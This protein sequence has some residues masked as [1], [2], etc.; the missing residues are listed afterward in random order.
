MSASRL[1]KN[2]YVSVPPLPTTGDAVGAGVDDLG[3]G[4]ALLQPVEALRVHDTSP[5]M[6]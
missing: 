1:S 4:E 3:A 5:L 2:V 6:K